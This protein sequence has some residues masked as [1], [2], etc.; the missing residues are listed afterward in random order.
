MIQALC[1]IINWITL[2]WFLTNTRTRSCILTISSVIGKTKSSITIENFRHPVLTQTELY[3]GTRLGFDSWAD[4]SCSGKHAYVESFIEG[5]T[6]N[7]CGFSQTLGLMKN[8]PIANVVYAYDSPDGRIL[9][10]ENHNTIYLGDAMEDSLVNPIQSEENNV[11]VDLRPKR[12]YPTETD[13]CQCITFPDG[14]CIELQ[15]DGVLPYIPIRRPTPEELDSCEQILLTSKDEWD[16]HSYQ[17]FVSSLQQDTNDL[18]DPRLSDPISSYL[19]SEHLSP[20]LSNTPILRN[21]NDK[22][23]SISAIN[24]KRK[25]TLSAEELSKKW[26]IGLKTAM[27]TLQATTHKCI[28]TTGLLSRRFKTDKAQLRYKQLTRQ[29]GTFYVDYLKIN[30]K[31]LR[32][33][34]GG[35]IYTN[36]L[37]L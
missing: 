30:C 16:P 10:L 26:N 29:Y 14:T 33:Y 24:S 25:N 23:M 1:T 34:I 4:T 3:Q 5:K 7:A 36:K 17:G 2:K 20:M 11:R 35:T 32:G 6:V 37:G 21:I 12:F 27:R 15:Y 9:L 28:R 22:Y 31:S 8:L 19:S 18:V 13:Q